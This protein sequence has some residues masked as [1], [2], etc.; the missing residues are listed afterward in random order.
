[1]MSG[2][3][4][5]VAD[6]LT[7]RNGPDGPFLHLGVAVSGGSDSTALLL[8]CHDWAR[9][10]GAAITA[11]TVD[12]AL[13]DGSADEAAA[14]ARL[15]QRLGVDHEILTW[16]GLDG[17][18]SDRQGW[19]GQGNLQNAARQA[20]YH[21]LSK[22]ARK[23]GCAAVA[24]GHT[25][26]DQAETFLMR[27]AR[28]SGV[29]GLAAMR[30]DWSADGMRWLRPLL[31]DR[32]AALREM[33]EARGVSWSDDPSNDNPRFD[34]VK[35]RHAMRDLAELGLDVDRLV[36][37]AQ[38]MTRARSALTR[39]AHDAACAL[40]RVE[41]GDVVFDTEPFRELPEEIR[42]RLLAEAVRFVSSTPY[43]PRLEALLRSQEAAW[44]RQKTTLQGCLIHPHRSGLRITRELAAIADHSVAPGQLWD[45][46]WR[47][48]SDQ[49]GEIRALGEGISQVKH[50]RDAGLPRPTVM[51]SPALW[52]NYRVIAAPLLDKPG[53][54]GAN[55]RIL[56]APSLT[57]FLASVLSH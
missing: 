16:R 31:S 54:A 8:L 6:F 17:Q 44:D 24:L 18:G 29:D 22:A 1:M 33:L 34:R 49:G 30:D 36:A 4:R 32:R 20:R 35:M 28:G 45:G 3:N 5:R 48:A 21:L 15:C 19:D 47:L 52:S 50:W 12:H 40:C 51:A 57:D 37:T 2:M 11:F 10:T 26:E 56:T 41:A 38:G 14:V 43:R 23:A 42:L 27:L 39:M 25:K 46:R 7:S 9:L 13:R 53:V 55:C